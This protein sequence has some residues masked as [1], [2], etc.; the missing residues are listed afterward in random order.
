MTV[1]KLQNA[2]YIV[3]DMDRARAFYRD[4]L[5]LDPAFEDGEKW[6]QYKAGGVNFA[7]SS[8]DEAAAGATGATVVFEVEDV[9]AAKAAIAAG[10]GVVEHERDMGD[11]G[12]TPTFREDRKST[13][14]N[15]SH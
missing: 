15:S 6:T 1:K 9:S 7:L 11:H 5:G 12:R 8:A 10:G 2:Y 13:L 14:L 3:Q 4:V